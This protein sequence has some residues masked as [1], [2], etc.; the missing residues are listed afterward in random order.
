ML[1]N[2]GFSPI[3]LTAW[4]SDLNLTRDPSHDFL[5]L[6]R[7]A[8]VIGKCAL[9][10]ADSQ[11]MI[12]IAKSLTGSDVPS[13]LLPIG[14]DTRLFMPVT[15]A[16]AV[17]QRRKLEIPET[18]TVVLSPRALRDTYGHVSIVRAFAE[19]VR[20]ANVD[21]Y[22]V[23]KAYDCWQRDYIDTIIRTAA[24][25]GARDRIR[26]VEELPYQ[27][28]PAFYGMGNFAVNF[29]VRDAFP[30]TFLESLACELPVLTKRLPA[31]DSLGITP[32]LNFTD[33][34]SE[35][36]LA[37]GIS[38]ML[39]GQSGRPDVSKA[40]AYIADNFDE[41]RIAKSL[42]NAYQVVINAKC[43]Q[44]RAFEQYEDPHRAKLKSSI[45]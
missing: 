33:Q 20:Q 9:L 11:D 39:A 41:S 40:R 22:L 25:Q 43:S 23:F 21:A 26:I 17:E 45:D 37:R 14:I 8:E 32:Y 18:A 30:V 3:V 12:E 24:E 7:K 35:E 36:S 38:T 1:A 19:A 42:I 34:P 15:K 44:L 31:Y 28:L 5:L 2:A 13:M 29:P 10:I 6:R 27:E 16:Q 4:G